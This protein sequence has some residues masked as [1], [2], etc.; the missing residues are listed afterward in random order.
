MVNNLAE[1]V[2][3]LD[4]QPEPH[5]RLDALR[6]KQA[7]QQAY[8]RPQWQLEDQDGHKNVKLEL[9]SWLGG[10]RWMAHR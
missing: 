6:H 5:G 10:S 7:A 4:P 8:A 3:I 9:Q 2:P 1:D